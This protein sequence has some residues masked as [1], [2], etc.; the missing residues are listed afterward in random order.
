[1]NK[2]I[3]ALTGVIVATSAW[4]VG[5]SGTLPVMYINT[6]NNAPVTDKENYLTADYWIDPMGVAGVEAI[7]SQAEPLTTQIRGRGNYTWSGF[8]KKPY[9][10]KLDKKQ[11]LLGMQKSK[12]FALLAHADDTFGFLRNTAGFEMSRLMGL[13][14]TP[15]QEPVEVVLN[16]DYIGLY[17]LTETI[18]VDEDRV[19]VVE[20][21]DLATTDVDGGWLVEIDN[22]DSDPHITV[23]EGGNNNYDIWFTYK[24]PEEL[25]AEQSAFLKQQ[26]EQIN[27]DVYAD[28]TADCKWASLVDLESL[29]KFYVVQEVVDNYESFH[30]SCYMFRQRGE[31]EKWHFGPVWDFGSSLIGSKSQFIYQG[32]NHHQVWIGQ[33]C[34]F[35]QFMDIVKAQWQQFYANDYYTLLDYIDNFASRIAKAAVNDHERWAEQGYGTDN[36]MG[37]ASDVRKFLDGS[38]RWLAQQWGG[39]RQPS[40]TEAKVYFIDDDPTLDPWGQ[41]YVYCWDMDANH[42][43]YFGGWPGTPMTPTVING[44]AAWEASFDNEE[45]KRVGLIFGNGGSGGDNQT[46]DWVLEPNHLYHRN[47]EHVGISVAIDNDGTNSPKVFYTL[48][49]QRVGHP[50]PGQLYIMKQGAKASKIVF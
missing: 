26:M 27:A 37:R 5:P 15:T 33:M 29:A 20:Q 17:M 19:N 32:R 2:F 42:E 28:N 6:E 25:S 12:H 13:A 30:G 16:G 36:E 50:Q 9:R 40:G 1:M 7:G 22:Y 43:I 18:R 46:P 39:T 11:P 44:V 8:D 3:S 35:P 21:A 24:S 49:G 4:A 45:G 47:G 31:Q 23:A 34:R 14:W 10:L 41:V 38:T 48:Q